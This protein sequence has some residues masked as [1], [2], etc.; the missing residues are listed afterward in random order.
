MRSHLIGGGCISWRCKLF[1]FLHG[2]LLLSHRGAQGARMLPCPGARCAA[3]K[4]CGWPWT[5]TRNNLGPS[6]TLSPRRPTTF[7]VTRTSLKQAWAEPCWNSSTRHALNHK[8]P[9]PPPPHPGTPHTQG[10]RKESIPL[11]NAGCLQTACGALAEPK[12]NGGFLSLDVCVGAS[13]KTVSLLFP[14]T[15][16]ILQR[17]MNTPPPRKSF[18]KSAGICPPV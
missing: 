12:T 16:R 2:G 3:G 5:R 18:D 8:S 4:S 17:V 15:T 1:F 9:I 14:P 6:R 11:L 7:T 13:G 10:M